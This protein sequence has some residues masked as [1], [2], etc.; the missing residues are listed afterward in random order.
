M[1]AWVVRKLCTYAGCSRGEARGVLLLSVVLSGCLLLVQFG[2]YYRYLYPQSNM[3]QDIA[4]LE[5][6]LAQL[7][8][9]KASGAIAPKVFDINRA[10]ASQLCEI[11]GIGPVLSARIINFREKLGGF[12]YSAQYQEIY[13][14]PVDVVDRL[15][16]CTYIQ[17]DFS[18]VQ[19]CINTASVQLLAAHP[20]LTWSQARS[21]VNYREQHGLFTHIA[22]LRALVLIDQTTFTKLSRYV[23]VAQH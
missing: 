6:T 16:R 20:Y 3:E 13:E 15:Q 21:I 10:D 12:V 8:S 17:P 5:R 22:D 23:C 1:F 18:P 19:L 9:S 7:E 14:L 4:L 2:N 11:S